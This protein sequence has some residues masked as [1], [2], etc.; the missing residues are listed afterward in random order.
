[1]MTSTFKLEAAKIFAHLATRE[2]GEDA[3][4]VIVNCLKKHSCVEIDLSNVFMTPSFADEFMGILAKEM[5]KEEFKKRLFF[6]NT[7]PEI[8]SL[9]F[10]IIAN[11]LSQHKISKK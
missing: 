11:R 5:G 3:R 8:K 9:L 7:S 10:H 4:T 1:M 2:D 6:K